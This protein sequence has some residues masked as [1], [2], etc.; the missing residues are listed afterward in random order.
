MSAKP[1]PAP[2]DLN[3]VCAVEIMHTNES[4]DHYQVQ[5]Q[6]DII[7]MFM[8]IRD[9]ILVSNDVRR[10]AAI[11]IVKVHDEIYGGIMNH[12]LSYVDFHS[13]ITSLHDHF[14]NYLRQKK[15]QA[16]QLC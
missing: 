10:G 2:F 14:V 6:D 11:Y 1:A 13:F 9:D 7:P 5:E 16:A 4:S 3:K 8:E 12:P 15:M